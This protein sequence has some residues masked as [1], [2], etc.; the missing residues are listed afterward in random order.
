MFQ[1]SA[2]LGLEGL[3]AS[4]PPPPARFGVV[5]CVPYAE[6]TT[7]A[8]F[9]SLD[10]NLASRFG[11][12]VTMAQIR[13]SPEHWVIENS[14]PGS[15]SAIPSLQMLDAAFQVIE[16]HPF[17][18]D[19]AEAE[20]AALS[21]QTEEARMEIEA[22]CAKKERLAIEI[23][24]LQEKVR[25][26]QRDSRKFADVPLAS[27]NISTHLFR[28]SDNDYATTVGTKSL[29]CVEP[30]QATSHISIAI[31]AGFPDT[32]ALCLRFFR[33]GIDKT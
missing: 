30:L 6:F 24:I 12:E 14:R 5:I 9:A 21:A 25:V 26:T 19:Q 3:V 33:V 28:G 18:I 11:R 10:A 1:P 4:A 13:Q 17:L 8:Q 23:A 22:V 29:S 20:G 27:N 16:H 31:G 2:G 32:F 15:E 7:E